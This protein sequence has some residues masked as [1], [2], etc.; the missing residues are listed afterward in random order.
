MT[1]S[2]LVGLLLFITG[3]V[4]KVKGYQEGKFFGGMMGAIMIGLGT[5]SILVAFKSDI[6]LGYVIVFYFLYFYLLAGI[7]EWLK[8]R[9]SNQTPS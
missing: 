8:S 4:V 9:N 3:S 5:S 7:A 6:G 2:L 1:I